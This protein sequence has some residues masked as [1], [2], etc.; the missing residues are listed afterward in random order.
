MEGDGEAVRLVTQ[1]LQQVQRI[2]TTPQTDRVGRARPVD[3]LELLGQ[4]SQLDLPVEAE[5]APDPLGD[6][7]LPLSPVDQEEVGAIREAPGPPALAGS[8]APP[9]AR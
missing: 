8:V 9:S 1:P 4:G 6:M 3:L 2:G 7:Q 5:L